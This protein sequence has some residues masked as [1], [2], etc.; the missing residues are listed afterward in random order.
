VRI[1]GTKAYHEPEETRM[2]I[3]PAKRDALIDALLL[4]DI[5]PIRRGTD[6]RPPGDRHHHNITINRLR[7]AGLIRWRSGE[8]GSGYAGGYTLTEKG[9]AVARSLDDTESSASRQHFIDTGAY[10]TYGDREELNPAKFQVGQI[11][12]SN[13]FNEATSYTIVGSRYADRI[14]WYDVETTDGEGGTRRLDGVVI[15]PD[16]YAVVEA[17]TEWDWELLAPLAAQAATLVALGRGDEVVPMY[18]DTV[19]TALE[20]LATL[21]EAGK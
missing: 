21:V 4:G 2:N 5:W 11:V 16:M 18:D 10:L 17:P 19:I 6:W 1:A 20:L 13:L 7:E 12:R 15:N 14:W 9:Q 3:T 8:L